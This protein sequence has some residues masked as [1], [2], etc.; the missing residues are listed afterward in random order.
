[1]A[2]QQPPFVQSQV[3][4]PKHQHQASHTLFQTTYETQRNSQYDEGTNKG[5]S[6]NFYRRFKRMNQ[7]S[8]S[9]SARKDL[10]Q[11]ENQGPQRQKVAEYPP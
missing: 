8:G 9:T 5:D 2:Q 4:L 3:A 6:M 11:A 10:D 7:E 1:V